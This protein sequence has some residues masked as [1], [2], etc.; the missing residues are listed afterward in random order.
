M[1]DLYTTI[2]FLSSFVL[3]ITAAGVITNRLVSKKNKSK[4]V[5][6]CLL[7]GIAILGEW[8]GVETNGADAS[9][10]LLHKIAKLV[11]FCV[12]PAIS[13]GAAITYGKV[14]RTKSIAVV[15]IAHAVFE[16]LAL[17]NNW[18]FRIDD[19]N[20]YHRE[21]LYWIYIVTFALSVVYCFVCIVQGNKKYQARFGSVLILILCFW[22]REL[23]FKCF[24][25]K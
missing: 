4:I 17:F 10:I 7:I 14:N 3:I 12:A 6:L 1:L 2:V 19:E 20:F 5:V 15:L 21:E 13:V 16:V 23:E 25:P 9:F 8:I 22:R 18:V 24:V 11:E